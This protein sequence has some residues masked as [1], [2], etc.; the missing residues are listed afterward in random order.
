MI[1]SVV[2]VL[3]WKTR[4]VTFMVFPTSSYPLTAWIIGAQQMTS[5]PVSPIFLL[6]SGLHCRLGLRKLQACLYS[7][8]SSH[9][10][11]CL[12][13]L[14]PLSLCLAR[15]F[16]PIWF[17]YGPC[18]RNYCSTDL[19]DRFPVRACKTESPPNERPDRFQNG[20]CKWNSPPAKRLPD[21]F[22][23]CRVR[24]TPKPTNNRTVSSRG[25]QENLPT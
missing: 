17:Q 11:F 23:T 21:R 20:A 19:R 14:L 12:P 13:C 15:W 16:W 2:E 4:S 9:L 6:L 7:L 5:H 8:M 24:Q 10:F 22:Q 18:K 1:W 3:L 25:V